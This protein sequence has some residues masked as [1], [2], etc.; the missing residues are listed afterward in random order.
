VRGAFA[1][2]EH[3]ELRR[4]SRAMR[5]TAAVRHAERLAAQTPSRAVFSDRPS[6][7]KC[8][9]PLRPDVAQGCRRGPPWGGT[10]AGC[11]TYPGRGRPLPPSDPAAAVCTRPTPPP[12]PS[13]RPTAAAADRCRSGIS[14]S[15]RRWWC[16]WRYPES[17][18]AQANAGRNLRWR[19][20]RRRR[21]AGGEG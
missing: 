6:E 17:A 12:P 21:R 11:S 9:A 14:S 5:V 13:A 18:A 20:R 7:S 10:F 8:A 3:S 16:Y 1:G 15:R 19:R 2:A 4:R